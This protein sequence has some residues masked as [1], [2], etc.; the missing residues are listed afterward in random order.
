MLN[1]VA[2]WTRKAR[3]AARSIATPYRIDDVLL[4]LG[5]I[6]TRLQRMRPPESFDQAEFKIFS[7]FGEDGIIQYLLACVDIQEETFVEIGVESY[8][9]SNTRFLAL[10]DNWSGLAIDGGSQH[11]EFIETSDIGW[12]TDVTAVQEFLTVDNINAVFEK[13]DFTG[14]IGLLSIDV[15]GVDYWLLK[16]LTVV[17]PAILVMEYQSIFG[18]LK[19]L[20][21]PYAADFHLTRAHWSN[22]YFGASISALTSLAEDR[23]YSLV[24]GTS[25]GLNA[26]FVRDD[27]MGDLTAVRPEETWRASRFRSALDPNGHPMLVGRHEDRLR[28][29]RHLELLDLDTGDQRTIG[30]IFGV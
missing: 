26:F 3:T 9:E 22:Q 27:L 23:G 7:Q 30:D 15:D 17:R 6:E 29:I 13:Y 4:T 10:H 25:N 5:D 28:L 1:K 19:K 12:R 20:T 11:V 18:P 2:R 8:Q 14:D 24:G 21:V 16:A